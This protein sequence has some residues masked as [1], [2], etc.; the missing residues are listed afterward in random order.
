M[1]KNVDLEVV[2]VENHHLVVYSKTLCMDFV[3][4]VLVKHI[5]KC[6]I[7]VKITILTKFLS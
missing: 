4:S 5:K 2:S 7:P 1:V 3:Q 6:R